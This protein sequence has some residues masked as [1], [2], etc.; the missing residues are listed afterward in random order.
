MQG[1][2]MNDDPK[3]NPA[4]LKESYRPKVDQKLER[5]TGLAKNS[6]TPT[7]SQG[8]GPPPLPKKK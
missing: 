6:Y 7:T 1:G 4:H 5:P 3:K 2:R 8:D